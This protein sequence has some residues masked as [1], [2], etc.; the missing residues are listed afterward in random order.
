MLLLIYM[1]E[2]QCSLNQKREGKT[3][4]FGFFYELQTDW[5]RLSISS[6]GCSSSV[7]QT[8]DL[9]I[10][11]ATVIRDLALLA[12]MEPKSAQRSVSLAYSRAIP[13]PT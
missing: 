3:K 2:L 5:S 8:I 12:N 11:S 10:C 7:H 1:E 13:T 4:K 6:S 9:L